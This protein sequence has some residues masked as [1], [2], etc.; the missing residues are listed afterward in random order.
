[1]PLNSTK[2]ERDLTTVITDRIKDIPNPIR[3]MADPMTCPSDFLPWLA[4]AFSVDQWSHEWPDE[5]KRNV[6]SKSIEIHRRKGTRGAIERIFEII[7]FPTAKLFEWFEYGGDPYFFKIDIA[8][9]GPVYTRKM[10]E[11]LFRLISIHK[12]VRS[13]L[14]AVSIHFGI[15]LNLHFGGAV[16]Q[17]NYIRIFPKA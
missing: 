13:R 6:I 16:I 15:D 7:E 14:E 12:N 8:A 17:A 3:D 9:G 11:Q 2:L 4:W 5:K 1:M 10:L